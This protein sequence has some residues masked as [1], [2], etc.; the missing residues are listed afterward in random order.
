MLF[1]KPIEQND[2]IIRI[3]NKNIGWVNLRKQT[4]DNDRYANA[5]AIY[6]IWSQPIH[7]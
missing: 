3:K 7:M 2:V 5:Q 4:I 1:I 6:S